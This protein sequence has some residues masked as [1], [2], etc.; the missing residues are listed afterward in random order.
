MLAETKLFNAE[1]VVAEMSAAGTLIVASNSAEAD[2]GGETTSVGGVLSSEAEAT[3]IVFG[4]RNKGLASVKA[5]SCS[6][7]EAVGVS[8]TEAVGCGMVLASAL[9]VASYNFFFVPP[10]SSPQTTRSSVPTGISG[11]IVARLSAC[12]SLYEKPVNIDRPTVL[13]PASTTRS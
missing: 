8:E 2:S 12:F 1:Q 13:P 5:R 3:E 4:S 7:N 10:F 6:E 9:S 11:S